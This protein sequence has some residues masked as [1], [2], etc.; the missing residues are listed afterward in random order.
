[1]RLNHQASEVM[2]TFTMVDVIVDVAAKYMYLTG[3]AVVVIVGISVVRETNLA[4]LLL[5]YNFIEIGN[6]Q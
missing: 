2:N 6:L 1:M 5:N 3:L 4:I